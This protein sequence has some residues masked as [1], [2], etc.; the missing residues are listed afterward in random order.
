K[1]LIKY[2]GFQIAP[3][4]LEGLLLSHPEILDAV[5]IPVP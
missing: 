1:E 4:E 2:N 3:A 5:V